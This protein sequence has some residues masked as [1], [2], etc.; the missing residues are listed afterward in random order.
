MKRETKYIVAQVVAPIYGAILSYISFT[1]GLSVRTR[2]FLS[3]VFVLL[4]GI[5]FAQQIIKYYY[6]VIIFSLGI[7]F[8]V[9]FYSQGSSLIGET[10]KKIYSAAYYWIFLCF[11][12]LYLTQAVERDTV[13][14]VYYV[15]LSIIFFTCITTTIGLIANP[16]ASRLLASTSVQDYYESNIGGFGFIYSIIFIAPVLLLISYNTKDIFSLLT[17]I[18]VIGVTILSQYTTAI[19]LLILL[20][21]GTFVFGFSLSSK[22]KKRRIFV[23]LAIVVIFLISAKLIGNLFFVIARNINYPGL[24]FLRFRLYEVGESLTSLSP[25]GGAYD[26]FVRFSRSFEQFLKSPLLGTSVNNRRGLGGHST[27]FD[28]LGGTGILGALFYYGVIGLVIRQ[29][30]IRGIPIWYLLIIWGGFF[31]LTLVN[32]IIIGTNIFTLTV[33]S[34]LGMNF[35]KSNEFDKTIHKQKGRQFENSLAY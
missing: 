4:F 22:Q 1:D 13:R 6:L 28:I 2:L 8:Q 10:A 34:T 21:G 17:L 27:F 24:S 20:I 9:L 31:I 16:H 5:A 15:I 14:F 11:G 18:A 32:P 29:Q 3:A 19:L 30:K 7:L 26:R 33:F 35:L 23:L 25:T 12:L